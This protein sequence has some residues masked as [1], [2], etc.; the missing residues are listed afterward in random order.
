MNAWSILLF[1]I[2][3]VL[4][5]MAIVTFMPKACP[6]MA[7]EEG[8][9]NESGECVFN[10]RKYADRYPDLKDAFGYNESRLKEHYIKN[11]INEGRTPCGNDNPTCKFNSKQYADKYPDLKRAFGYNDAQLKAHYIN[12]GIN[13]GR[14]LCSKYIPGKCPVGTKSYTDRTGNLNCCKGQVSGNTCEGKIECSFSSNSLNVPFCNT[15][16]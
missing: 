7:V 6:V 14:S 10:A 11:G 9:Q 3:G 15:L 13:E 4:I 12:N 8:F 5:A 2:I 1:G 16:Y